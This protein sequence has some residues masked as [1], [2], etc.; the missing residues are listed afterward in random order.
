MPGAVLPKV[1]RMS[2]Q[3][4]LEVRTPFLS[5][6][7]ARFA[8]RLPQQV[9][10]NGR[11]ASWCCAKLHIATYRATSSICR[12]RALGFRFH[13]GARTSCYRRRR[14]CWRA[15]K[16]AWQPLSGGDAIA[17]FMQRQQSPGGFVTYQVWAL[18]M[19]ESWL[20]H[21]PAQIASSDPVRHGL[22]RAVLSRERL[23]RKIRCRYRCGKSRMACSQSLKLLY[24]EQ[25][26]ARFPCRHQS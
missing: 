9:L 23:S 14:A 22:A 20:R 12:K 21:H 15:R 25:Q 18:T 17:R 13:V 5:I 8:E 16:A 2:M 6:E 10:Y 1:D 24:Q 11:E 7:L 4:S 3:H 26:V 19:L